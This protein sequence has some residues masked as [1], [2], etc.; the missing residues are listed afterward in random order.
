[1]QRGIFVLK[2][3]TLEQTPKPHIRFALIIFAEGLAVLSFIVQQGR[4]QQQV[5]C[6]STQTWK[7]VN[8]FFNLGMNVYNWLIDPLKFPVPANGHIACFVGPTAQHLKI[9]N[10]YNNLSSI[11]LVIKIVML[12][13][14][15][16][17]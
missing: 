14:L 6:E 16:I 2:R 4:W 12:R 8:L 5:S 3:V 1:M 13:F 11:S 7:Y 17:E 9:Y 10:L 15:S